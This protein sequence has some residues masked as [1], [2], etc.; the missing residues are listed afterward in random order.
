[1]FVLISVFSGVLDFISGLF[2][3]TIATFI[4]AKFLDPFIAQF[5]DGIKNNQGFF[6]RIYKHYSRT[7]GRLLFLKKRTMHISLFKNGWEYRIYQIG[8]KVECYESKLIRLD[9]NIFKRIEGEM[10]RTGMDNNNYSAYFKGYLRN[11]TNYLIW[12][13]RFKDGEFFHDLTTYYWL[14]QKATTDLVGITSEYSTKHKEIV[15]SISILTSKKNGYSTVKEI[16][17]SVDTRSYL[18]KVNIDYNCIDHECNQI[19]NL[20]NYVEK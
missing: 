13:E 20:K 1:M 17:Q 7:L 4:A 15:T 19:I 16:L 18:E 3:G 2:L 6:G 11:S 10:L 9:Q 8:D 12:E 14:P 5:Y